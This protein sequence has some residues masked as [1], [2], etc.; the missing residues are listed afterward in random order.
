[1][2]A[3]AAN[4]KAVVR[5]LAKFRSHTRSVVYDPVMAA[6]TGRSLL[7]GDALEIIKNELFPPVYFGNTQS[8]RGLYPF[9]GNA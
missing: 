4:V 6:T 8:A 9:W 3:N 2:L 5:N 7:S 1:M